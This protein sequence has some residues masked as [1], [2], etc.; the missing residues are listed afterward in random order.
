MK[1]RSHAC[2]TG[3]I[4]G[5]NE[6]SNEGP[7]EDADEDIS[8]VVH[9]QEHDHVRHGELQRVDTGANGLLECGWDVTGSSRR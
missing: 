8:V 2:S 3:C 9:C 6:E 5:E 7:N 4:P 1:E